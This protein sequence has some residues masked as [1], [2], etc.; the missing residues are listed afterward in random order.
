[1]QFRVLGP[2]EI[3]LDGE[4][5]SLPRRQE[6]CLLGILLLTPGQVVPA[7]RLC[8]L[9]WD[10]NPPEHA[11]ATLRTHAARIRAVLARAGDGV[12]LES[13]YGGYVLHVDPDT[14]DA[15]VFR[16]LLDRA[17]TT[18]EPATRDGLLHRAL[19]LWHGR[20]LQGAAS[21][22]LRTRLCADL[23]E[24]H[25][26]AIEE[27]V[28]TGLALG[29]H[30]ELLAE[31]ADLTA[32][33][34]ARERLTELHMRALYAAGQIAEAL[35]AYTRF[36]TRLA[37]QLGLDPS[38]R[39][40]DLHRAILRGE[41]LPG[42]AAPTPDP[43]RPAQ[44]PA[45]LTSFAGRAGHLSRLDDLLTRPT[46]AVVISA[47]DGT[48]GVGKT[49][50]AVHWAHR[51]RTRF[52]DGQLYVNLRGFDPAD[53]PVPPGDAIRR[54]LDALHVP[55]QRIPADLDAQIGLY[56]SLLADKRILVLLDNARDPDQ[57]RP[58]LAAAPGCLT[59]VTSRNRLTGLIA[60]DGAQ[61]IALDLLSV[62][63]ARELL[64]A[65]LGTD[66]VAAEPDA[67]DELIERCARLPLALSIAAARAAIAPEVPLGDIAAQLSAAE[68]ALDVLTGDDTATNLRAVFACS[69]RTLSPPAARLFRLLG[70]HPGP[71]TSAPAAASLAGIP[72]KAVEPLIAEL[73]RAHLL[74]GTT[75]GRYAFHDLL[76]AY[77]REMAQAGERDAATRRVLDHY[78]HT[79]HAAANTL[80][81][82]RAP[83]TLGPIAPGVTP[84]TA[85]EFDHARAMA[86]FT[87]EHAVLVSAIQRAAGHFDLHAWQ[88]PV[89][90]TEYLVRRGH[91]SDHLTA[92]R[93]ALDAAR[94]LGDRQA[95][96]HVHRLL[97]F[98]YVRSARPDDARHHLEQA[99][100]LSR[101]LGDLT[102]EAHVHHNLGMVLER[103]GHLEDAL[104]HAEQALDLYR[105]AGN[106]PGTAMALNGVG[107]Y[108]ALLGRYG[109]AL[110]HCGQGL[111]LLKEFGDVRGQAATWD[112]LGYVHHRQGSYAEA[113]T[114][115][116]HAVEMHRSLGERYNEALVLDHLGDSH[117]AAGDPAAA[118]QAWQRAL[119]ILTQLDHPDADEVRAKLADQS[120]VDGTGA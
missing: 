64:A 115:Y 85:P 114:C 106:G 44:L 109:P 74:T 5:I 76:R 67:V 29:R 14:V 77:A 13:Q 100:H 116:A 61:P 72:P 39:L 103:Q 83:I 69:Y 9:L 22:G 54:F 110:E 17:E 104:H 47:I 11:R 37:D 55:P 40:G 93:T 120:T 117:R 31:L 99:L 32:T 53:T 35:D 33:H 42:T 88:L 66:R 94:R 98:V 79:A 84:E 65:R 20:V 81:P 57:V 2:V 3:H 30:R 48:G 18:T 8:T 36:R 28:A 108:H 91:W 4:V 19:A 21:D 118:A 90:M 113:V 23:E 89:T 25:L 80:A 45:D 24:L 10:D 71:D 6:R 1:V 43:V 46:T 112:S 111:A 15:H 12:S 119:T 107:W 101:E 26:H 7:D 87:A 56:R 38:A 68:D 86:W 75:P 73:V 51:V 92:Q 102:S 95:A 105:K 96:A 41:R 58:L 82:H 97:G 70:L 34:P 50:L 27:S 59:V 52:P 49:A 63:E 78:L 60:V 62:A 16:Q